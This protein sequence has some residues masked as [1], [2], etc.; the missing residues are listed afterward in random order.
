MKKQYINPTMQ[1]VILQQTM[2]IMAG[3]P[4]P[5]DTPLG[6]PELDETPEMPNILIDE[7][8]GPSLPIKL[9]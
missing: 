1:V 9:I 7:I 4:L 2:P 5:G 6:A 8:G 3:S